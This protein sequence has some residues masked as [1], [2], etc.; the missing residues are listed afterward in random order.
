[1]KML[2]PLELRLR[3]EKEVIET[4]IKAGTSPK[5]D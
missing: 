1:M 4:A 3:R 2:N 5:F